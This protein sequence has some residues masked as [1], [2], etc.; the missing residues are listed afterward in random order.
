MYVRI[1]RINSKLL[2]TVTYQLRLIFTSYYYYYY[3][4]Y[5]IHFNL[6]LLTCWAKSHMANYK[7]STD[8]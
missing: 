5:S 6:C 2:R 3:Y 8:T 7:N 4:Y 1:E